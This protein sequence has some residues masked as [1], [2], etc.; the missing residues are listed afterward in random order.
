MW[1]NM[2]QFRKGRS[3]RVLILAFFLNITGVL[4]F[5]AQNQISLLEI[6]K[7]KEYL[8]L[9]ADQTKNINPAIEKIKVILEQDKKI[10]SKLRARFKNGDEPGFFEK[11]NVK[12]ARDSRV[13]QVEELL[14][15]IE[16]LLNDDQKIKY[17]NIEKPALK[18]LNKKEL[19]E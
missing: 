9:S 4:S 17:K 10:I 19:T 18:S 1:E 3:I 2:T 12:R 14:K 15:D 7:V 13:D 8:T 6:A 16:H 5:P 11:I